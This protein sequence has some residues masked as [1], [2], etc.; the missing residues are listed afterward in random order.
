VEQSRDDVLFS[1]ICP[2]VQAMS[3][4]RF[5]RLILNYQPSKALRDYAGSGV[6]SSVRRPASEVN[7]VSSGSSTPRGGAAQDVVPRRCVFEAGSGAVSG[8]ADMAVLLAL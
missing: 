3:R 4:N 2:A 5:R 1:M 6:G 8:L 7:P